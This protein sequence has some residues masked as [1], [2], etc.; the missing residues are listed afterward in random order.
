M[1]GKTHE[2]TFNVAL[3]EVLKKVIRHWQNYERAVRVEETGALL[4][5]DV[6]KRIDILVEHESHNPIAIETA[7][8]GPG[9]DKDA[10]A[11]IQARTQIKDRSE[12]L[13]SI[14]VKIPKIYQAMDSEGIRDSLSNEGILFYALHQRCRED[15]RRWP[16]SGFLQ[17]GV[18]D[19]ANFSFATTIP[20]EYTEIVAEE[21]ASHVKQSASALSDLPTK[22]KQSLSNLIG[23]Q[24]L[25]QNLETIALL[26]L[27]ACFV[28]YQLGRQ[29]ISEI[30]PLPNVN[31]I[32]PS[33]LIANWKKI[34]DR[35]WH[36]IFEPAVIA[37]EEVSR[38]DER[39]ANKAI[40]LLIE[41]VRYMDREH[42]GLHINIG[43]ELFPKINQDR[44]TAAAFYT[45][46]AAAELLARLT[47]REKDLSASDWASENL[48]EKH[49]LADLA[50]GTGT[51]LRAGY[52]RIEHLYKKYAEEDN[53]T[54]ENMHR[55]GMES[56][57]IGIDISPLAAHLA[58][59]SLAVIGYGEP[60]GETRI[61]WVDVG[62]IEG[63]TGAVEYLN[64]SQ[65]YN[66]L[67]DIGSGKSSGTKKQTSPQ[68]SIAVVDSKIDW[69]LM[70]PPYSR[71]RGGQS[72]FDLTGANEQERKKCQDRWGEFIRK[73]RLDMGEYVNRK[74][75]MA[76]TFLLLAK[77]KVKPKG[78]IG[79]VLPLTAA[80]AS[81]WAP[82][83]NM[84]RQHFE[85]LT[86]I[87]VV[88]G[89]TPARNSMSADTGMEEMLLVATRKKGLPSSKPAPVHCVTLSS[90]F[91]RVGE[92]TEIARAI[93]SSL[94]KL[95]DTRPI[96]IGNEEI[97][98]VTLFQG[99]LEDPWN[100][101]GA[102]HSELASAAQALCQGELSYLIDK[103]ISI[104]IDMGTIESL[105]DVGPTHHLIGHPQGG[106]SI[107]AFEFHEIQNNADAI[108]QDRS[109]WKADSQA[110]K[111]LII[112]PTH[113]GI[114]H[115][116]SSSEKRA[117]VRKKQ[118]CLFYARNMRWTSQAL[119][120]A[121]TERLVHGGSTW[122]ALLHEENNVQKMFALW[123]NSTFGLVIHWTQG[124]RTQ[125][126]RA[127][128][129][130]EALK[131]IPCPRFDSLAD[132]V[133]AE[134]ADIFD[135][136]RNKELMPA[137]QAHVDNTRK[138]IDEKI[139]QLLE[140]EPKANNFVSDL[141]KLWCQE[142]SVHGKNKTALGKLS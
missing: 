117:N 48:F 73:D 64:D 46:P 88:S 133:L 27:N 93:E 91:S 65:I 140:L 17:G 40:A 42:L 5:K 32:D 70:N 82:T 95:K 125:V 85:D 80:F 12:I 100:P 16:S 94:D 115:L 111:S 2:Q 108:G 137:C 49:F 33:K 68:H 113:K 54:L 44:K 10:R 58:T 25:L 96:K 24:T 76:A 45:Q 135:D 43:A 106:D 141:R 26:W 55:K 71:T 15:I 131:K 38:F 31:E 57:L 11:R 105:F 47:I 4:G 86:A 124:Q 129:Q 136:L 130:I 90:A 123:A 7:F 23:H 134:A 118:S 36:S 132:D 116:Q 41:A 34:L 35:N 8:D 30:P 103:P 112:Q 104:N 121:M 79:F 67:Y 74:A 97:G 3:G 13:T 119:L 138:T 28:Q 18:Y 77:R 21:V 128:T 126:G 92:A 89:Q 62:G 75:G 63:K 37:L 52:R 127:R 59:S 110:Q 61:G 102:N 81:T 139:I 66:L 20:K 56:G 39:I 83:R 69:V 50:C 53:I 87:A 98:Y 120:V 19:L 6:H 84:L 1:P 60:Y 101:L 78:R 107:G 114:T 14:A 122:T 99:E 142:P 29:E 22:R 51:L 9:A 109:L 72:V